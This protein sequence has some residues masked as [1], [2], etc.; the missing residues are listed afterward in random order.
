MNTWRKVGCCL[1]AAVAALG[2]WAEVKWSYVGTTLT[3]TDAPDGAT[4]WAFT[5]NATTGALTKKTVGTGPVLDLRDETMPQ[6]APKISGTFPSLNGACKTC[7]EVYLPEGITAIANVAFSDWTALERIEIPDGVTEIPI[8]CCSYCRSLE[9][10]SLPDGVTSI[11]DYAFLQCGNLTSIDL[12]PALETIGDNAFDCCARLSSLPLPSTL[13]TIGASAFSRCSELTEIVIPDGVQIIR[14][15]TFEQCGKLWSVELPDTVT[16]IGYSAF[17]YC[18]DL[19]AF[20]LPSQLKT[21]GTMAFYCCKSLS[22]IE[23]PEGVTQIA[24]SAFGSCSGL[25]SVKLPKTLVTLGEG[26]FAG[27]SLLT[28]VTLPEGLQTIG[29]GAFNSCTSLRKFN[30]PASV[31]SLNSPAPYTYKLEEINV[32]AANAN[33]CS[34]GGV[35][36]NKAC[37]ELIWVPH[38]C[39]KLYIPATLTTLDLSKLSE[40]NSLETI[41]V[42]PG[43]PSYASKFGFL[44]NKAMTQILY[45]G[46]GIETV[47]LAET[48]EELTTTTFQPCTKVRTVIVP[49][50]FTPIWT[51]FD[52]SYSKLTSVTLTGTGMEVPNA[53]CQYCYALTDVH[54]PETVTRIGTSAFYGCSSLASLFLPDGVKEIGASAFYGCSSLRDLTLGNGVTNIGASAFYSCRSLTFLELPP[55]VTSVGNS[56]LETSSA[57]TLL[58]DGP[59]P[60]GIAQAGLYSNDIVLRPRAYSNEWASAG[61]PSYVKIADLPEEGVTWTADT[62]R[63]WAEANDVYVHKGVITEDEVW[64]ADKTH[65]VYG[66]VTVLNGVTVTAEP[67]AVVKFCDG[68]GLLVRSGAMFVGEG[69]TFTHL[70]DDAVGGDSDRDYGLN[71]PRANAYTFYGRILDDDETV[72]RCRLFTY[73]GGNVGDE[74]WTSGNIYCLTGDVTL[75]RGKTLTIEEGAV[76][77]LG[78]YCNLVVNGTLDVQGTRTSPAV[79]TSRFDDDYGGESTGP[80]ESPEENCWKA[81]CIQGDDAVATIKYALFRYGGGRQ[82]GLHAPSYT[83]G[84]VRVTG[85]NATL[86]GCTFMDGYWGGIQTTGGRVTAQNCLFIGNGGCAVYPDGGEATILNSVIYGC[87]GAVGNQKSSGSNGKVTFANCIVDT[88]TNWENPFVGELVYDHCCFHNRTDGETGCGWAGANGNI[89]LDPLLKDPANGDFRIGDASPCVDSG[90]SV[91]PARDYWGQTRQ[92]VVQNPTGQ[93][94]GTGRYPDIGL[95]EVIPLAGAL[96]APDL[97]AFDVHA[98][99]TLGVG[100]T[101]SVSYRVRN[102]SDTNGAKGES[103]DRVDL[104]AESGAVFAGASGRFAVDLPAG[105][106]DALVRT[107]TF[108]VPAMPVGTVKV[109]VTVNSDRDIFEGLMTQNNVATSGELTLKVSEETYAAFLGGGTRTLQP[110]AA[111]SCHLTGGASVPA[112]ALIVIRTSPG[113]DLTV[114]A[115]GTRVPTETYRD[116]VSEKMEDGLYFVTL[117]EG[118]PYVTIQNN[119]TETV[120]L[121][122][123]DGG[124]G[125]VLFDQWTV[126]TNFN[127][128]IRGE[129]SRALKQY[130]EEGELPLADTPIEVPIRFWGNCFA[131]DMTVSLV[132]PGAEVVPLEA[133]V[134]SEHSAYAKFDLYGAAPGLYELQVVR[135]GNSARI[136]RILVYDTKAYIDGGGDT[137]LLRNGSAYSEKFECR[138]YDVPEVLRAGHTYTACVHWKNL[139]DKEVDSPLLKVASVL[140]AVRLDNAAGWANDFKFL[141]QSATRPVTRLKPFEEG[142]ITFEFQA[143]LDSDAYVSPSPNKLAH[144]ADEMQCKREVVSRYRG[145]RVGTPPRDTAYN[146][147]VRLFSWSRDDAGQGQALPAWETE[148]FELYNRPADMNDEVWNFVKTRIREDYGNWDRTI[149]ARLQSRVEQIAQE[150]DPSKPV[151]IVTMQSVL[152][153]D[154][155]RIVGNDPVLRRLET[156]ADLHVGLRGAPLDV[157]RTYATG[158][159]SRLSD[160]M[161]GRGWH[162]PLETRLVRENEKIAYV[163]V[164]GGQKSAYTRGDGGTTYVNAMRPGFDWI[165]GRRLVNR[166]GSYVVFREA[167]GLLEGVYDA[168]DR[169]FA[170][171]YEEG[172]NR[173]ARIDHTDGAYLE[174]EYDGDVVVCVRDD[175]GRQ[176][177]YVYETLDGKKALVAVTNA[178]GAVTA[179]AYHPVDK[180]PASRSLARIEP[181]GE[182]ALDFAWDDAGRLVSITRGGKF[183]TEFVRPDERTVNV[184]EPNGA[185]ST[186]EI[187][188]RNN[189]LSV[190]EPNGEKT[191]IIYDEDGTFPVAYE[192]PTGKRTLVGYNGPGDV[193][194]QTSPGGGVVGYGYTTG[195][196][197]EQIV[198]PDGKVRK[199]AYNA[200]NEIHSDNSPEGVSH[201]YAYDESGDL[202]SVMYEGGQHGFAYGYDARHELVSV[203]A[204]NADRRVVFARDARRRI[205]SAVDSVSGATTVGYSDEGRRDR[206]ESFVSNGRR[207]ELGYDDAGRLTSLLDA[208]QNGERY[209]Y[210]ALGR[211]KS[212]SPVRSG[213]TDGT[214]YVVNSYDDGANGTGKLIRER[215]GNGTC[216]TYAYNL[217]GRVT[218]MT[219]TDPNGSQLSDYRLVYD[220][221][222]KITSITET[223]ASKTHTFG[224][225]L[226]GQLVLARYADGIEQGFGYDGAGNMRGQIYSTTY[227]TE[228]GNLLRLADTLNG[229]TLCGY[230]EFGRLNGIT[231][232]TLGVNWSCTYDAFGG[233][234]SV[235][236]G[237]VTTERVNMPGV[238]R[239]L[240][241]YEGGV[242]VR[243]HVWAN[244]R[245][246][247]VVRQDGV[248]YLHCDH[249]CSVRLVTDG[250]GAVTGRA[251]FRA[252]GETASSS[253]ADAALCGWIAALG[254]ETDPCGFLFM[255]RRYY[256][257]QLAK[258]ISEDPIG[259][260]GGDYNFRRYC[261]NDPLG[262]YDPLGLSSLDC[263]GWQGLKDLCDLSGLMLGGLGLVAMVAGGPI[264]VAVIGVAA[265]GCAVA[266]A[267][268][269]A[270]MN[271]G[272]GGSDAAG[273]AASVA[274]FAPK[275]VGPAASVV[276]MGMTLESWRTSGGYH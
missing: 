242:R 11:G 184:V 21:I 68:M 1:V 244:G 264:A 85:G 271:G 17:S 59:P 102:V 192:T 87:A 204:S 268:I 190:T 47:E 197:L 257:V 202:T 143:M 128:K 15:R 174:F 232:A 146:H 274:G 107:L 213:E 65:V 80:E 98:P 246:I 208:E 145:T 154:I 179:Y 256:S 149:I 114:T 160:G 215:F 127:A 239:L 139:Q 237:F 224:Y 8:N 94:S 263:R 135:G 199:F 82:A 134:F 141:A 211:L 178:T 254:V 133:M 132:T 221:D 24:N 39:K 90:S 27:C 209:A 273:V 124:A 183:V 108:P 234:Q 86:E 137:E 203:V 115:C 49:P 95:Y 159:G 186:F 50:R 46:R 272:I 118:T 105:S 217:L 7:R 230:D 165:D 150:T 55:S 229:T 103:L 83:Y 148:Q 169:G 74:I 262:F 258:F 136:V 22:S 164:A 122:L 62:T 161:F 168:R 200:Q 26:A 261:F 158:V 110:G 270:K 104:V 89:A 41:E 63:N 129:L 269:S 120:E 5:V 131:E 171:T 144:L 142:E 235:T 226:D 51:Y 43:N 166:D 44:Y 119:G 35:L 172:T 251:E 260:A 40:R 113:A 2:A 153:S 188:A 176:A 38:A 255:G 216:T 88:V 28:E 73:G 205:T 58:V 245:R 207:Y 194:R 248:R 61:L 78:F 240:D 265:L 23:I 243:H 191:K 185:V 76:V 60:R 10:V 91:A 45:V 117:P 157:S 214:P 36:Y 210:D 220:A 180:T 253:G 100:E 233:R 53:F 75:P 19:S 156:A 247:A 101:I 31:T 6:G 266:S 175:C 3:Q 97:E 177:D 37:T 206:V 69:A 30:I 93:C 189:I 241:E 198:D 32:A 250:T 14:D 111:Y 52:P 79:F 20:R 259:L 276:G 48:C 187:G 267:A 64:P 195:G 4:P 138:L 196:Q 227:D 140:T 121:T 67:G 71:P 170:V 225:D 70:R 275:A 72:Y 182:A 106:K 126:S 152:N 219:T 33:Y 42:D 218:A 193:I 29:N 162:S 151:P 123:A 109:R 163:G 57:L 167:D 125:L 56:S 147:K 155:N 223:V 238:N 252:F 181:D 12:P 212:V 130:A 13:R 96:D 112:N 231:N 249:L 16:S 228:T 77:T 84:A 201:Y 116:S 34:I 9:S 66:W 92:N 222:G 25:M 81:V 173:I 99:K 54:L 18:Y 236:S